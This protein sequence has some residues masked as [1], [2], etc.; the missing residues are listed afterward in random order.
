MHYMYNISLF[1]VCKLMCTLDYLLNRM[2]SDFFAKLSQSGPLRKLGKRS[3][4]EYAHK[5]FVDDSN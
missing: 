4:L 5:Q 1:D 2:V 3:G